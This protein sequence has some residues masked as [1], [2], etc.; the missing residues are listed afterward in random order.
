[1]KTA[2]GILLLFYSL[3]SLGTEAPKR[4]EELHKKAITVCAAHEHSTRPDSL[5]IVSH[6]TRERVV[7][8]ETTKIESIFQNC[9]KAQSACALSCDEELEVAS[10]EGQD[11]TEPMDHLADCRQGQVL[12][13]LKAMNKKISDLRR[14]KNKK[15][16]Q[17]EV[18]RPIKV[19]KSQPSTDE[20]P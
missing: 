5:S 15:T 14:V 16:A 10:M 9:K 4:C 6:L 12:D 17:L 1:M 11:M 20:S 19:A 3:P 18:S 7:D 2:I 8:A 13:H